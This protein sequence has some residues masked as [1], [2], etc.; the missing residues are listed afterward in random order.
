M[1]YEALVDEA[2]DRVIAVGPYDPN[3]KNGGR[4]FVGKGQA[5]VDVT[6]FPGLSDL[7]ANIDY[8][9]ID[10]KNGEV[11]KHDNLVNPYASPPSASPGAT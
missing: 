9:T 10:P 7:M 8:Y 11:T 3:D 6:N 5:A 1:G 4:M 2:T